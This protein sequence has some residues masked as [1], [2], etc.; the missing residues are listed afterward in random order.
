MS[1]LLT[2]SLV[3]AAERI[4]FWVYVLVAVLVVGRYMTDKVVGATTPGPAPSPTAAATAPPTAQPPTAATPITATPSVAVTAAPTPSP[5]PTP[6]PLVVTAYQNGARRF[7]ALVV[8]V[9]HTLTSPI[10]GTASV[11]VYQFLGGDVRIGSNIPSEPFF[12]YITITS[13]DRKLILRPGA[14]DRDVQ[15]IV[16]DGQAVAIGSPLFR[17]VS[18][19]ASSWRTFYDGSVA[20]QVIASVAAWPSGTDLDPVPLFRP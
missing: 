2:P 13:A 9:G 6:A 14:L 19:G 20:A 1:G 16:R 10:A 5:Q 17:T 15:L 7:A 3:R 8:P 4:G 18:E 11:V 12:P